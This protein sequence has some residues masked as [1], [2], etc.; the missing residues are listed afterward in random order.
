MSA[1]ELSRRGLALGGAALA[2]GVS[3]GTARDTPDAVHVRL[4][5][6]GAGPLAARLARLIDEIAGFGPTPPVIAFAVDPGDLSATDVDAL[7]ARG[8]RFG[9]AITFASMDTAQTGNQADVVERV[10]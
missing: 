7:A 10:G 5:T 1:T 9:A 3:A 8:A 2:V 4:S 6:T